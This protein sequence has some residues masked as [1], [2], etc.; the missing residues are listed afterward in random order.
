MTEVSLLFETI[1]FCMFILVCLLFKIGKGAKSRFQKKWV[2]VSLIIL[3]VLCAFSG[4]Y[5]L[6]LFEK[7]HVGIGIMYYFNILFNGL[8]LLSVLCIVKFC[9]TMLISSS[10]LGSF[11]NYAGLIF[12]VIMVKVE[13][14]FEQT[15]LLFYY[16]PNGYCQS[17][18][19]DLWF[20]VAILEMIVVEIEALRNYFHKNN[21]AYQER[22]RPVIFIAL[23]LICSLV[24]QRWVLHIPVWIVGGTIAMLIVYSNWVGNL[25]SED[26]MTGL[27]N[28][29]QLYLDMDERIKDGKEWGLIIFDANKFKAINDSY[30]HMEGDTAIKEIADCLKEEALKKDAKAYRFGGDEFML[31]ADTDKEDEIKEILSDIENKIEKKNDILKKQYKLSL[32][33]GYAFYNDEGCCTIP[34]IIESADA[35]MYKMKVQ[36]HAEEF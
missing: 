12:A 23:I 7:I 20:Y 29:R 18:V 3:S 5:Y 9:K 35:S 6:A 11:I 14:T 19:D 36:M 21:Y 13:V 26:E 33:Y 34:E 31:I 27:E 1:I 2:K 10:Q 28:K 32:S 30:G 24:L 16:G 25:I 22:I 17:T 8:T 15:E 4:F